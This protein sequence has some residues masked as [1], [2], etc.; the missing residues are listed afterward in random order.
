[1]EKT[2]FVTNDGTYYHTRM[3]FVLKNAQAEFQHMVND[4]FGDQIG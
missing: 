2:T 3:P 4:V 1:M